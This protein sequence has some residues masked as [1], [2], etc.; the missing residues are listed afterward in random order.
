MSDPREQV[1]QVG[2]Y[3]LPVNPMDDLDCDSCQ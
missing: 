3:D 1:E 2:G